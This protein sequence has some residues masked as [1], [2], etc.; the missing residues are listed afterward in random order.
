LRIKET[1][2]KMAEQ[3]LILFVGKVS[4]KCQDSPLWRLIDLPF[5]YPMFAF[6]SLLLGFVL[7]KSRT[8]WKC[9]EFIEGSLGRM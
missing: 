1:L 5:Q 4:P 2:P 7:V 3:N 6:V 8:P 9:H